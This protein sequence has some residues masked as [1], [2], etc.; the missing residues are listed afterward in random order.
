M[1]ASEKQ[2]FLKNAER[3]SQMSPA[4]RQAWRDLV[5]NVPAMAAVAPGIR[6]AAAITA[7]NLHPAVATNPN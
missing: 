4:E 5:A 1:S 2:E 6:R 7:V 3:W